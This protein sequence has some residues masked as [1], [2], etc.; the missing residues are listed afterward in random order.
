[1]PVKISLNRKGGLNCPGY[2]AG[3]QCGLWPGAGHSCHI[4]LV[5]RVRHGSTGDTC[6]AM[7]GVF[8][9]MELVCEPGN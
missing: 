9:V 6:G 5:L 8:M 7:T 3:L 1:M 2:A 4:S